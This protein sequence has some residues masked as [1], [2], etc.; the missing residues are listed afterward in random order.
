MRLNS[1]FELSS[2]VNINEI[3][4][5]QFIN[6]FMS[7]QY[8]L[9]GNNIQVEVSDLTPAD[10]SENYTYLEV[11]NDIKNAT[12]ISLIFVIRDQKYVYQIKG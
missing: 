11:P 6:Y 4:N 1:I 9:E 2:G 12:K 8:I 10:H 7:I 3:T 5:K